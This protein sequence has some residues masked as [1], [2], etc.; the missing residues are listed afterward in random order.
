MENYLRRWAQD[1]LNKH[2]YDTAVYVYDKLLALTSMS[3]CCTN[4]ITTDRAKMTRQMRCNWRKL[5]S[6]PATTSAPS[7]S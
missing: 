4:H 7:P 1:S 3:L 2:Q 6:P 5:T